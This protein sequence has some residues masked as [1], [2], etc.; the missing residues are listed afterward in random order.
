MPNVV[1]GGSCTNSFEPSS[2]FSCVSTSCLGQ[3]GTPKSG[4]YR[5]TAAARDFAMTGAI[6]N[7][8]AGRQFE[9][10]Q[11]N[12]R[13]GLGLVATAASVGMRPESSGP[14]PSEISNL[15]PPCVVIALVFPGGGGGGSARE[16]Q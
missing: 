14:A 10:E 9:W 11:P 5:L 1:A 6:L 3:A 13:R 12:R 2:H 7:S 16:G 8:L 4:L 15:C